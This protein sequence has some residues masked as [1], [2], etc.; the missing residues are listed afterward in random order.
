MIF[1]WNI[2]CRSLRLSAASSLL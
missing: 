2:L 1:L